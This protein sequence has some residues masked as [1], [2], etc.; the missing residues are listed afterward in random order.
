[1]REVCVCF[2]S[3][4]SIAILNS[5]GHFGSTVCKNPFDSTWKTVFGE[6]PGVCIGSLAHPVPVLGNQ[7]VISA[8]GC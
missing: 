2:L 7:S 5:K 8:P 6:V 1:M 4:K 3:N